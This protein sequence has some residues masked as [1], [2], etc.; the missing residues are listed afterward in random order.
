MT[1]RSCPA[2]PP[3]P[4]PLLSPLLSL[5]PSPFSLPPPV[6]KSKLVLTL[7]QSVLGFQSLGVWVHHGSEGKTYGAQHVTTA[8]F[9]VRFWSCA[10]IPAFR[11]TI[12][13]LVIGGEVDTWIM[14][15]HFIGTGVCI[16]LATRTELTSIY[17]S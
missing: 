8:Q 16:I 12:Y 13:H 2:T 17:G 7:P 11:T 9:R 15:I 3:P 4:L 14:T 10:V 6:Y 1:F 5:S